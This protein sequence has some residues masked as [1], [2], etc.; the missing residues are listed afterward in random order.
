MLVKKIVKR[1]TV[2]EQI[3]FNVGD[4]VVYSTVLHVDVSDNTNPQSVRV[5]EV[6]SALVAYPDN[7]WPPELPRID[8]VLLCYDASNE[9]SFTRIPELLA[10]YH[11]LGHA[12][13]ILACKSDLH[14]AVSPS[15]ANA[16]GREYDIGLIEVSI[17]TDAG[18]GKIRNCFV[19][20]IK[21]IGRHRRNAAKNAIPPYR[22]PASP[23]ILQGSRSPWDSISN[24]GTPT[25]AQSSAMATAL[26]NSR[27]QGSQSSVTSGTQL[28]RQAAGAAGVGGSASNSAPV[29]PL[30]DTYAQSSSISHSTGGTGTGTGTSSLNGT[31]DHNALSPSVPST[32][33][34]SFD[35]VVMTGGAGVGA[36]R[37]S[38][39]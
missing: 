14:R 27:H 11:A 25:G 9:D 20:E 1:Y 6:D 37:K 26:F 8:G 19:W 7:L 18:K 34:T 28:F 33:R 10:G 36:D 15:R 13:V 21:A 5:L 30:A 39:V 16:I 24:G 29:L 31:T 32:A 23:E 22:N 17:T 38:V 12:L 4:S 3:T 2:V 35:S